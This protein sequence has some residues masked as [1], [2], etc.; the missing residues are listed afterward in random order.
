[1]R[2]KVCKAAIIRSCVILISSLSMSDPRNG[3]TQKVEL[4]TNNGVIT[5]NVNPTTTLI[6]LQN[7]TFI[8]GSTATSVTLSYQLNDS[9]ILITNRMDKS[10]TKTWFAKLPCLKQ[11][12][13]I[14][15]G[16]DLWDNWTYKTARYKFIKNTNMIKLHCKDILRL[17]YHQSKARVEFK[18]C[19]ICRVIITPEEMCDKVLIHYSVGEQAQKTFEMIANG[20][21]WIYDINLA[22]NQTVEVYYTCQPRGKIV[23]D[24]LFRIARKE[25]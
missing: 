24:S 2:A 4:V 1:M 7:P 16:F 25:Y 9:N 23:N 10:A 17:C 20:N 6:S 21:D 11:N 15:F 5:I 13:V 22:R 18:E 14:T 8:Q 3:L 12:D 19:D